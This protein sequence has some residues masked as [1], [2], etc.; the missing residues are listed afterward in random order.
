MKQS[1]PLTP[2]AERLREHIR[3]IYNPIDWRRF[4]TPEKE[5]MPAPANHSHLEPLA[6]TAEL[7]A[8][9]KV[10]PRHLAR[11]RAK[12][13]PHVH[14]NKLVRFRPA[15]VLVWLDEQPH[16]SPSENVTCL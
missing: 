4:D 16:Q 5:T 3:E 8:M 1:K 9:L 10:S 14:I 11:L 15:A 12:G 6:D 2:A 13:L 7:A